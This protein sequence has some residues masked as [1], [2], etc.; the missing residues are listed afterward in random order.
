MSRTDKDKP[1]WVTG[2]W[3]AQHTIA[4][5][6]GRKPSCRLETTR[7]KPQHWNWR[8]YRG[9]QCY[10]EPQDKRRPVP[11][12]PRWFVHHRWYGRDRPA[13]R[14]ACDRAR[15]EHRAGGEPD[16]E[17]PTLQHRHGASWDWW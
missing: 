11:R 15:A 14:V 7:W 6:A 2:E 17:P 1:W 10:W 8:A 4:C 12:P 3:T 13:A 5:N 9:W 16:T